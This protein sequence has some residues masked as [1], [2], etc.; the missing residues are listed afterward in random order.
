MLAAVCTL[1]WEST[2]YDVLAFCFFF[3]LI[4]WWGSLCDGSEARK[5][6]VL[7]TP[8]WLGAHVDIHVALWLCCRWPDQN[9]PL[10]YV[11]ASWIGLKKFVRAQ[12][13]AVR[14]SLAVLPLQ[15]ST[16][17]QTMQSPRMQVFQLLAL[18][19]AVGKM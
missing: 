10:P 9:E 5:A 3:L 8:V 19:P 14:G 13:A 4:P 11:A 2:W 6:Q 17:L 15:Q 12:G 18:P 16:S 1:A 7:I